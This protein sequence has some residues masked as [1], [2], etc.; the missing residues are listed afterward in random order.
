MQK[1]KQT[2]AEEPDQAKQIITLWSHSWEH[3]REKTLYAYV[4]MCKQIAFSFIVL[5]S[6]IDYLPLCV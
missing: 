2:S 1:H 5:L 6:F 3:N 4:Y